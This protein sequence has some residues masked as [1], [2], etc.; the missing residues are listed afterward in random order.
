M[1]LLAFIFEHPSYYRLG[2]QH[3]KQARQKQNDQF[4][5]FCGNVSHNPNHAFL[6]IT[7][8]DI[9]IQFVQ[10]ANKKGEK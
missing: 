5:S 8:S 6:I 3:I 10:V 2:Q 1:E 4:V 9:I 7:F